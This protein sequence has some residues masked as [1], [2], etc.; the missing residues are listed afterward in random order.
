MAAIEK[1]ELNRG[2]TWSPV[3][4]LYSDDEQTTTYD[5]T[6][7]T[8]VCHIKNELDEEAADVYV[9]SGSWTDA[10]NGVGTFTLTHAQS[11]A[12]FAR[13]YYAFVK[14]YVTAD[15]SVVKTIDKKILDI[16]EVLEKDI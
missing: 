8:L 10:A 2:D 7:Y 5:A 13:E 1:I 9:L 14:I 11:K 12:L 3:I 6:G 15:N 16:Q 4:R